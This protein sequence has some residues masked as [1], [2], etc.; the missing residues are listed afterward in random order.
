MSKK[1]LSAAAS[2]AVERLRGDMGGHSCLES[3]IAQEVLR[4]RGEGQE[5]LAD[6]LAAIGEDSAR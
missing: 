4:L 5:G 1:L 2:A 3:R 6:E